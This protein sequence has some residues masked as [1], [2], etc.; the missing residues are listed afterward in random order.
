MLQIERLE[1]R[2]GQT[3]LFRDINLHAKRGELICLTGQSGCGKTTL[4]KAIMGL[5]TPY[6]GSIAVDN[7]LLT[8]GSAPIIRLKTAWMPQGLSLPMDRVKEMVR[9]PFDL[10]AN[11][12]AAFSEEELLCHLEEL[13]LE[14]EIMNKHMHEISGGQR[15]RILLAITAMQ[16]KPLMIIDEPT[17]ALDQESSRRVLQ[18][19][20]HQASRGKTVVAVSH[21]ATFMKGC[22]RVITLGH[23]PDQTKEEHIYLG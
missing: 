4:L 14:R 8:P 2:F 10:K 3:T 9:L 15:Q 23:T 21:D 13:G 16:D 7:I 6:K 22:K 18:F 20:Q 12:E 19:V 1:I 17:S 5:V 11:K